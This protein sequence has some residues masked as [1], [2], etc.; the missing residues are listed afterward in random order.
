[1][2]T[3]IRRKSGKELKEAGLDG[4]GSILPD[5]AEKIGVFLGGGAGVFVGNP[6]DSE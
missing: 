6:V 2:G 3:I 5:G 1:M 4:A